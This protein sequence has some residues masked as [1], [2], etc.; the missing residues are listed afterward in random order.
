MTTWLKLLVIIGSLSLIWSAIDFYNY[1]SI[2]IDTLNY[3]LETSN[4]DVIRQLV[5]AQL[6]NGIFKVIAGTALIIIP[7]IKKNK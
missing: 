7:F 3:Y 5:N 1:K 4:E 2:G 6:Q